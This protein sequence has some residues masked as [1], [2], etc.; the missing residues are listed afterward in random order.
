MTVEEQIIWIRDASYLELFRW[1]RNAPV[2]DSMFVGEVGDYYVLKMKERRNQVG[3]AEH[4]R[5]SKL[6]G[7]QKQKA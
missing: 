4:V 6:I 2:G 5:I 7:W 1:W 3:D